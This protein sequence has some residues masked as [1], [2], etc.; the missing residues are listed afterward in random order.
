MKSQIDQ[1][2]QKY[3]SEEA[4]EDICPLKYWQQNAYKYT[5]LSPIAAEILVQ[6][7]SSAGSE[8][9]FSTAGKV[10][11]PDRANL[12]PETLKKYSYINNNKNL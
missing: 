10:I 4:P 6:T 7:A 8:R 5:K 1:E 3:L 12:A 2:I 9:R 11:R